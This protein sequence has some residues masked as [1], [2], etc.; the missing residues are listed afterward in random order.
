MASPSWSL[1]FVPHGTRLQPP[2]EDGTVAL[3]VGN[4]TPEAGIFDHHG[5][6]AA[7]CT[8]ELAFRNRSLLKSQLV[9]S[10]KRTVLLHESPDFD[11]LTSFFLAWSLVAQSSPLEPHRLRPLIDF[12]SDVD[13]GRIRPTDSLTLYTFVLMVGPWLTTEDGGAFRTSGRTK[14]VFEDGRIE[15]APSLTDA[16][17]AALALRLLRD[18]DAVSWWLPSDPIETE[19]VSSS[20]RPLLSPLEARLNVQVDRCTHDIQRARAA[21]DVGWMKSPAKDGAPSEVPYVRVIDPDA[22][23]SILGKYLRTWSQQKHSTPVVSI[24]Q[25]REPRRTVVSVPPESGLTLK[26]LGLHLEQLEH[27]AR[28]PAAQRDSDPPRYQRT[29]DSGTVHVDPLF[30]SSDPWYDG[31]GHNFTIVDAPRNGSALSL[32]RV[33]RAIVEDEWIEKAQRYEST[34]Y[35]A[36]KSLAD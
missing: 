6:E 14:R 5:G 16:C 32:D 34:S 30:S 1:K 7:S 18:W 23:S 3:D 28:S 36:W 31:R 24:L 33:F 15:P 12:A 11:A 17:T 10:S 22:N 27:G 25:F 20:L 9:G 26:G 35:E 4:G 8:A 29:D 21:D 13:Q 19:D 2:L